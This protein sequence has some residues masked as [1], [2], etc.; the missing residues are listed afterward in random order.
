MMEGFVEKY[1]RSLG[2]DPD[3]FYE[4]VRAQMDVTSQGGDDARPGVAT[5]RA[6]ATGPAPRRRASAWVL[7]EMADIVWVGHRA[8]AIRYRRQ[9]AEGRSSCP[10][11]VVGGEGRRRHGGLKVMGPESPASCEA[12]TAEAG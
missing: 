2:Y 7:F 11:A 5:S 8:T 10:G 12:T 3:Q 1:I 9:H 6:R 4:A